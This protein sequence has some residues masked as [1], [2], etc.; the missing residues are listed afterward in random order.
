MGTQHLELDEKKVRSW[1]W[2]EPFTLLTDGDLF[3][4][5][6]DLQYLIGDESAVL[7]C[8]AGPAHREYMVSN[9]GNTC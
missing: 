6:D 5:I 1:H 2:V 7:R 9:S 3:L 8:C 4:S